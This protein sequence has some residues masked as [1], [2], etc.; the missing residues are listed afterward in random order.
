[1]AGRKADPLSSV[2]MRVHVAN[3]YQYAATVKTIY[4]NEG[5]R[6][7]QYTHWG[8]LS[9]DLVFTPNMLFI[10][11][12]LKVRDAFIFP[13]NWDIS[14]ARKLNEEFPE[15]SLQE[16]ESAFDPNRDSQDSGILP[17]TTDDG[18]RQ[19]QGQS[20]APGDHAPD[21]VP[22]REYRDL[23]FGSIWLLLQI[24]EN[25]SVI[26]DL[27]A[28]FEYK[29]QVVD[30]I[31]TLAIFPYLT[32][33]NY[34]RLAHEQRISHY[35][36]G[37]ELTSSYITRFTQFITPQNRMDF[38]KL[39]IGRQPGGAYFAC[40]ST[41][42]SAWG[43]CIAEI[44]YGRNKDNRDMD[45]TLEVVVYS[46]TTHEP[47]YYRT[48]P[49]NEP[50]ARTV[51]TIISDMRHLGAED[52]VT[53]YD[54]GYES[55]DNFDWF[56]RDGL[57][58][59]SCAKIAQEP[60]INCLLEIQYDEQGLPTNMKYDPDERL[61]YAQFMIENRTYVD[62]EGNTA[63]VDK[64]D[65]KCNAFLNPAQRPYDLISVN[66]SIQE[67]LEMLEAMRADGLLAKEKVTIN[68]KLRFHT[69][70]FSENP[71]T[72]EAVADIA[73]NAQ[74]IRKARAS[75]GFFSSVSYKA[76]GDA[77]D[78]LKIYRTRDEQEKYFEQMKDQMDFHTVE[79]SSQD[80][81]SGRDF[82]L[83]VGLILSSVLRNT[84]KQSVEL[85]KQFK[86]SLSVLD[87][88]ADIRWVRHED[89]EE[90]MSEFMSSQVE[91]CKAYGIHVPLECLPSVERKA[92]EKKMNPKKR[93]RKPKGTAAPNKIKVIPC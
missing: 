88:M 53:I 80:G 60:V 4:S 19:G 91:I 79:C 32:R 61:F 5:K 38:C 1:M 50:D 63:I 21:T 22:R 62:S 42:R 75:C 77:L 87:E 55:A 59:I 65:Y 67:E 15:T 29:R 40:D 3:N 14:A 6:I 56:F 45:C 89:G 12:P 34:D 37:H 84:W 90:H 57:A 20:G 31:L 26:E 86:T 43:K 16:T 47:V 35:P 7:R 44:H 72:N 11:S 48:F 83:F 36:S 82:I 39:R 30:D 81:K 78:M 10:M 70:S 58:F 25:K 76:P 52:I 33:K 64:E 51:R 41:T 18:S 9:R 74:A 49:G 69:V 54:R 46:L 23:L 71:L 24:A 68:R 92:E 66:N 13:D 93:G 17:E 8:T 73:Q 28:T 27:M 2:R 85:R